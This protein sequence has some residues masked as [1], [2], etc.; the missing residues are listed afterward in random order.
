MKQRGAAQAT[1]Q[2]RDI[3]TPGRQQPPG[4]IAFC[5]VPLQALTGSPGT[6][7][8]SANCEKRSRLISPAPLAVESPY[9]TASIPAARAA[10]TPGEGVVHR[11]ALAR[12]YAELFRRDQETSGSGFERVTQFPSATASRYAPRPVRSKMSG[13]FLLAEARARL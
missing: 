1:R 10:S 8:T 4:R 2:P 3:D 11:G 9:P 12:S 7:K 13:A 6:V 5:T